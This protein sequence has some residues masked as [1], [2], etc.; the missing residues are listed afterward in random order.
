MKIPVNGKWRRTLLLSVMAFLLMW[1]G[2]ALASSGGDPGDGHGDVKAKGWV[3][4]D[5]YRV[6]NFA[7][8]AAALIFLLRKPL[9]QALDSR[10]KGIQAQLEDLETKKIEAEKIM[11]DYNDRIAKL[12]QESDTIVAEYIRQG[13]EAKARILKE[14][15]SAAFKLEEQ[16]K[17]NIQNEFELAKKRLQQDIF[18]KAL[19]KA[20]EIIKKNITADDQNRLVDEYLDKVVAL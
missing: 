9:S 15:E 12:S 7:V 20:E 2:L 13:N 1:S 3:A 18:E 8:L 5:T 11:A 4:T 14:A 19:V 17:R 6:L 10:I 16:A